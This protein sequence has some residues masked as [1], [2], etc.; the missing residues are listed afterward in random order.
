VSQT[1]S[2]SENNEYG[3]AEINHR[4]RLTIPKALRD[5]MHLEGGE[6]FKVIRDG[7][8]IR[9]VRQLPELTTL[10]SGKSQ[11]EWADADAFRDAGDA[12]F[13]GR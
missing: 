12:T 2:E 3:E 1:D 7:A 4:G 8:E 11:D 10:S 5:E 13:G 6:T 9:L